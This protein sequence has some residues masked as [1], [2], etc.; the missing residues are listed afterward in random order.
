MGD[1]GGHRD[2]LLLG[3]RIG[4]LFEFGE[5]DRIHLLDEHIDDAAAGQPDSEG[6]IIGDAVA[7]QD[8][9]VVVEHLLA[10]FENR[11]LHTATRD[12]ADRPLIGGHQH[13]RSSRAG[14]RAIGGYHRAYRGRFA[15][16]PLR[17][18]FVEHLTHRGPPRAELPMWP[19][20]VGPV[21]KDYSA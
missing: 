8:G 13:R 3:H 11:A 17:H 5:V 10:Q 14:S 21:L 4:H 19:G 2:P 9:D 12:T 15:R 20:C 6:I 1:H 16:A 18:Q 7:L